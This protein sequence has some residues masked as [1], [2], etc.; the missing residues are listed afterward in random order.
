MVTRRSV[1]AKGGDV[2]LLVGTLKGAFFLRAPATRT[3]WAVEGPYLP[4]RAVYALAHDGR[5]GRQR[6][7]ASAAS[8]HWG[9]VLVS[10]DDWGRT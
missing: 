2:V 10:T 3:A 1:A 9:A 7:W 6:I 5:E 4:G 8:M